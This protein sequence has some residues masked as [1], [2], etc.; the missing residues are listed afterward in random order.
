M[1]V[2]DLW[3]REQTGT[4][5]VTIDGKQHNLKTADKPDAFIRLADLLRMQPNLDLHT[6]RDKFLAGMEGIRAAGTVGWY[7]FMLTD[8]EGFKL[9]NWKPGEITD[10]AVQKWLSSV[11]GNGNTKN[12][13]LRAFIRMLNWA[14]DHKLIEANP[15][16]GI[17]RRL[18]GVLPGYQ[19]RVIALTEA[20][21][22][23]ILDAAR[24]DLHSVLYVLS[25]TGARPFEIT[26]AEA[27]HLKDGVLVLPVERAKSKKKERRIVLH[28]KARELVEKLA[29][30]HK[31]GKLFRR[32]NGRAWDS[33]SLS[34]ACQD[35][36]REVKIDFSAYAFRHTYATRRVEAKANLALIAA[37]M[38]NSVEM[39]AKVYA[40]PDAD[41][42]RDLNRNT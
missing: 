20:E 31:T 8:R 2:S 13:A 18:D 3:F 7:R 17:Q 22:K 32:Q 5:H 39:V 36:S 6:I 24:K 35:L 15:I 19:P 37:A 42:I 41:S 29:R 28:D 25:E 21:V 12:G 23:T 33:T 9:P 40:H 14:V 34:H 26:S 16:S 1:Q 11:P 30:H 10:D 4:F 38:G 27:K